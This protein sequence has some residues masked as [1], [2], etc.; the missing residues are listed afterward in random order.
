MFYAQIFLG[1]RIINS[2]NENLAFI[3]Q[4]YAFKNVCAFD[5]SYGSGMIFL[6]YQMSIKITREIN[7]V[8]LKVSRSRNKTVKP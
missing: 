8:V 4:I 3:L 7:V 1:A 6:N 5:V 2:Q